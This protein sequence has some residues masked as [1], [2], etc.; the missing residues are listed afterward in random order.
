MVKKVL[1]AGQPNC[2]KSSIFNM[3]T[4]AKQHIANYPGITVEKK[5]GHLEIDNEKIQMIDLPGTYSLSSYTEEEVVARNSIL[6][7]DVNLILNVLDASNLER[8][9]YLTFQLLEMKVPV[10]LL[11]NM[12]DVTE[13]RGYT[14]DTDKIQE[15]LGVGS[16]QV[17]AKKNIGKN[18]VYEVVKKDIQKN[19]D[20]K[21]DY[22]L[23]EKEIEKIEKILKKNTY[24][25]DT[26]WMAI[27][28]LEGD[29]GIYDYLGQGS[30]EVEELVNNFNN[31]SKTPS[32]QI[33][34]QVRYEKA[35]E[36]VE[37][38][39]VGKLFEKETFSQKL[40]KILCHKVFG[41]LILVFTLY[42]FFQAVL[43]TDAF[44]Q[45]KWQKILG[46]VRESLINLLPTHSL[47]DEGIVKN[48]VGYNLI[49]GAFA[50]LSYI[51]MF[52]ILFTL[53]GIMEDSGYMAR[54][55]FM[56]DRL[57]KIF[58][59][60]GQSVLPLLLGGVGMGGC[61]I[62]GIMATR[63][64]KDERAKLVTR[65]IVPILNCGAKIPF[66]LMIVA[67]F[68]RE[69]AAMMLMIFYALMFLVVLLI[70]KLFDTFLVKGEKSP[71]ILELPEYRMPTF[72]MLMRNSFGKIK[73]F[74]SRIGTVIIPFMA[75]MWLI[76]SMPNVPKEKEME[77]Q[78]SYEKILVSF[79]KKSGKNNS[80]LEYF[81]DEEDRI[82]FGNYSRKIKQKLKK[83]K[84]KERNEIIKI[85]NK[86]KEENITYFEAMALGNT[87][88]ID[89]QSIYEEYVSRYRVEVEP[90]KEKSLVA[91]NK[92]STKELIEN[93][94]YYKIAT[95]GKYYLTRDKIENIKDFEKKF[96]KEIKGLD[97]I[98]L[99]KKI[100][101]LKLDY[102]LEVAVVKDSKIKIKETYIDDKDAKN[103]EKAY[104]GTLIKNANKL[105]KERKDYLVEHSIGG[106]FGK[107]MEPFTLLAGFD[108][109]VNL[110]F[111]STFAAKENF[112]AVINGIFGITIDES[113]NLVG[114]PWTMLNGICL[115]IALALF[116]P[117]IPT[118]VLV[119]TETKKMKWM[120]FVT[121]YPIILGYVMSILIYQIGTLLGI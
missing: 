5:I 85:D 100:N 23:L 27:K 104:Y 40:D 96:K 118:L 30:K 1:L 53:V 88:N 89:N 12:I 86:F 26:R 50:L 32:N 105:K 64:M 41:P 112:V 20:F 43:G 74:I 75:I 57:L 119:K 45:P 72:K 62:P 116:P 107:F 47:I 10:F 63:S 34:A 67:A 35:E 84:D 65:L 93:P 78:K 92:I 4:G 52:F 9:L 22:G 42:L 2:G 55:A 13:K 71:F 59:L 91:Y 33:I 79:E 21:L 80:Y 73:S 19:N 106:R 121:T 6:E 28:A 109:R 94:Q 44:I 69:K 39:R 49:N 83:I 46:T 87:E 11:L 14:F 90:I 18:R 114:A 76:T 70:A 110:A 56:L 8:N 7:T 98:Q 102:P 66:Y 61:A 25:F 3:L 38:S 68:F 60:H 82:T 16:L 15:L 24:D 36:I 31:N 17:S 77:Y 113:G 115:M 29:K 81:K 111:I 54:I 37:K 97:K 120:L 95:G 103:I 108:W 117:C 101:D 48:L 51:P 58:G 99:D